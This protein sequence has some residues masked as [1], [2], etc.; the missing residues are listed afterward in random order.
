MPVRE[1]FAVIARAAGRRAPRVPVP[2]AVA[3]AGARAAG[4]VLG[5]RGGEPELLL[6]DEVRAGR[7]PHSFDDTKARAEL[8]YTSRPAA[9][10]LAD[11]ARIALTMADQ[12]RPL[13]DEHDDTHRHRP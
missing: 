2:W 11:A 7:L 6:L 1:V 13:G 8:G 3:Y 10:A 9:E 4:A 12:P 5:N